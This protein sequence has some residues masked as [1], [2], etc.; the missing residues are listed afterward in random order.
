MSAPFNP[1]LIQKYLNQTPT[2]YGQSQRT[3]MG[4]TFLSSIAP[5]I[6]IF[7]SIASGLLQRHWANKDLKRQL[8]Y[9]SLEGQKRQ[10]KEAGLPLA[11]LVSGMG[12][13]QSGG[14][15]STEISPDLGTAKG[16]EMYQM[17][18]A[19]QIEMKLMQS[20][21]DQSKAMVEKTWSEASKAQAEASE[22]Q[23]R[24]N[25][26]SELSPT[27][28]ETNFHD[29][30]QY[31]KRKKRADAAISEAVEQIKGIQAGLTKKETEA[32]IDHILS[33]NK[34]LNQLVNDQELMLDLKRKIIDDLGTGGAGWQGI[35]RL[36][37]AFVYKIIF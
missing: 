11:A 27:S 4:R 7:G 20:Q 16:L 31:D 15:R 37:Q 12:A 30:V 17:P 33:S 22:A 1:T 34:R 29:M 18:K 25:W 5:A 14:Q 26:L 9:N 10:A 32:R 8:E 28:G 6:P 35:D 13:G 3:S 19:K 36:I 24:A 2:V 21:I 23:M